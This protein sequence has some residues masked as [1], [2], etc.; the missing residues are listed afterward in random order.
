M[1]NSQWVVIRERVA[2]HVDTSLDLLKKLATDNHIAVLVAVASNPSTPQNL[3]LLDT[4]TANRIT[5]IDIA[6]ASNASTS[7]LLSTA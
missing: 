4:L 3:K 7:V 6:V 5:E 2:L 1:P